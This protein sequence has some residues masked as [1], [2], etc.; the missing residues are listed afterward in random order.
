MK[1]NDTMYDDY[2]KKDKIKPLHPK[3][4]KIYNMFPDKID[5]IK[6]II[7]Y[8][9]KGVGKYTQMLTAIKQYSQS[10]LK[11]EKKICLTYNKNEYYY[12]ISDIHLEVDM[13]LLGCN[14][15]LLWNE[16][17]NH[18]ID[19]LSAKSHNV[20]FIVCKFFHEIHSELLDIFYSYMQT[21]LNRS[22]QLK[23]I[24]ITEEISFIPDCIYNNCYK[25]H[26]PRPTKTLYMKCLNIDK[27]I[28]IKLDQITNIKH[29]LTN[30]DKQLMNPHQYICDKII[31]T[32]KTIN[33]QNH[34]Y[35]NFRDLLYNIFIYNVSITDSVWYIILVLMKDECIKEKDFS[36]IL[37]RTFSFFQYYNNN[38]RPIYH[39]ESYIYYLISKIHEF[40]ECL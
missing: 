39:L 8:G 15:K 31:N 3:L 9:P 26:V 13:S 21:A 40:P 35:V 12:N 20:G 11:Y 10:K 6:N 37:I 36:D 18:Y 23:F 7:F 29:L 1:L 30:V 27:M 33:V 32:I 2:I 34:N 14:S 5:N 25:I 28:N 16:I 22:I 38:Y 17:Y 4:K 24:I 19:I